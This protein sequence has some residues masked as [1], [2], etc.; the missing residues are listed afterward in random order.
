M[1]DTP[2]EIA[3]IVRQA[4]ASALLVP[5][6]ILRRVIKTDRGLGGLG[7]RVPHPH[8]YHISRDGL[9]KI[10][11]PDELLLPADVELPEQVI[12]LPR[13]HETQIRKHGNAL[14]LRDCWRLLF[15]AHVHLAFVKARAAGGLDA[16]TVRQRIG[17]IGT[18]AFEEAREVLRQEHALF[19][20]DDDSEVYEEFASV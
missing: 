3:R 8:L 10:A 14:V 20:P 15:H 6:R 9:L 11:T 12:L 5:P 17:R 18:V 19:D 1:N 4:D 13:P 7:L 2:D 16:A